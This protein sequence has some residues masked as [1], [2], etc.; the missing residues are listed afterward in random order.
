[1]DNIERDPLVAELDALV[2]APK[3][4]P[5]P[6]HELLDAWPRHRNARR[7]AMS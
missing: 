2:E 6:L 5:N 4:H 1:M 7:S 3:E